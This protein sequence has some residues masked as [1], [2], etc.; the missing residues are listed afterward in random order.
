MSNNNAAMQ[1][2]ADRIRNRRT[3]LGYSYQDLANLTGMNKSSLQRYET[4]SIANIPLHRLQIIANSLE[5]SPSWLMGWDDEPEKESTQDT[6]R[7]DIRL[8]QIIE[9]Y[10]QFNDTGKEKLASY[11]QDL[12]IAGI[13]DERSNVQT[14]MNA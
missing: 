8:K 1:S 2:I 3:E 10:E 7:A 4:G 11:A 12:K 14:E 6:F 13:Y 5:V 9:C